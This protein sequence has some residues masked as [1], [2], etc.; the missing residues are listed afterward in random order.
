MVEQELIG[1]ICRYADARGAPEAPFG[2][3]IDGFTLVRSR[4]PTTLATLT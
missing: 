2:T 3:G 1:R 4:A